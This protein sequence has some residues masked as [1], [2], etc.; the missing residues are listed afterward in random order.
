MDLSAYRIPVTEHSVRANG[1]DIWYVEAGE[2]VPLLLLHGGWVSNGPLWAEHRWSW[3]DR[4]GIFAERFRVIAPDARGYGRTRNPSGEASYPLFAQDVLA[5]VEALHLDHPLL[6]GFSDGAY[7]ATLTGILAPGVARAIVDWEGFWMFEPDPQGAVYVA[8]R[9]ALGGSP[10]ATHVDMELV[11]KIVDLPRFAADVEPVHGAGYVPVYFAQ[12][13]PYW[14]TPMGYTYD[15]YRRIPVPTLVQVG[16]R[17]GDT[18]P[19]DPVPLALKLSG[20]L[21]QGEFGVLPSTGH[22][23]TPLGCRVALDFL[24]R[25]RDSSA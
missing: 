13:F 1:L 19:F 17:V 20:L 21:P 6:C 5:L 23:I 11:G 2:G 16:N 18:S 25:H 9:E 14:V 4:I 22:A 7:T 12:H 24:L 3:G 15:D 8:S 10:T